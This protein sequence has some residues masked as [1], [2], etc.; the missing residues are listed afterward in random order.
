L[1]KKRLVIFDIL[2][3]IAIFLIFLSHLTFFYNFNTFFFHQ[4]A[5]TWIGNVFFLSLG[6][7]GVL[8]FIFIS[9]A[10]LELNKKQVISLIDY[11]RFIYYRAIRIYP[12]YWISLIF[13][14]AFYYYL[15]RELGNLFWQVSGFNAF[16]NQWGGV[17]NP[18]GWFI[19]LLMSLYLLF[20]FISRAM[21]KKPELSL[22][23]LCLVSFITTYYINVVCSPTIFGPYTINIARWFPLCS[24]FYFGIGIFL[25]RK[26]CYPKWQEKTI[27]I[28]WLGKLSFYLFLFQ[29]PVINIAVY[30]RNPAFLVLVFPISALV[31]E[32]DEKIQFKLREVHP[33]SFTSHD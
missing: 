7:I 15:G 19:G 22:T 10:V 3:I 25:V 27:I 26:G 28:S 18:V 33:F 31:M 29:L 8:L 11:V 14:A 9:G 23:I 6:N 5:G 2:R 13:A 30:F 4:L 24:L 21:D 20:P 32:I 12:A 17:L 16:I 1:N